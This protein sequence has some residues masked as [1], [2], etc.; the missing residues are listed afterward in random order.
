MPNFKTNMYNMIK[1][2]TVVTD[3][4]PTKCLKFNSSCKMSRS[5]KKLYKS[6]N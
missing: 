3:Y 4:Q 6:S 1:N 5:F 2:K